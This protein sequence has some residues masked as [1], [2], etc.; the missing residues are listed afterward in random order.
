V[1]KIN[2]TCYTPA[3]LMA[4][5]R[6]GSLFARHIVLEALTIDDSTGFL[7]TLKSA[8]IAPDSYAHLKGEIMGSLPLVAVSQGL[9]ENNTRHYASTAS[10]LL[11]TYIYA[12]AVELGAKSFSLREV[13]GLIGDRRSVEALG[14]L[15]EHPTYEHFQKV[16]DLLFELTGT[17][18]RERKESLEAFVV[19][20]YGVCELAVVLGLRI[21]A[22]GDLL[23]YVFVEPRP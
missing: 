10:Y 18:R 8:Y 3:Q 7:Q 19:N 1:G 12:K 23:T 21:L 6:N 15:K 16:V 9:F 14:E 4:L 11:R 22:R 13:V 17:T 2:I 20:S 5:A